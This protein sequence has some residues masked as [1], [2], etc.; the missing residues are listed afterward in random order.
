[1]H[2]KYNDNVSDQPDEPWNNTDGFSARTNGRFYIGYSGGSNNTWTQQ[3]IVIASF[4]IP[5]NVTV[6]DTNSK[7]ISFDTSADDYGVFKVTKGDFGEFYARFDIHGNSTPGTFS[8]TAEAPY[9]PEYKPTT[10]TFEL[11]STS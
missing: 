1:L 9:D 8:V 10:K 2:E 3:T 6:T 5:T 4:G 11:V 7:N